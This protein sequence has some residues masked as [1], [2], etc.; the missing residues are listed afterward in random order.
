MYLQWYW[1]KPFSLLPCLNVTYY[2]Y[3]YS[4]TEGNVT[5]NYNEMLPDFCVSWHLHT[6]LQ[7]RSNTEANIGARARVRWIAFCILWINNLI[8]K[9]ASL[10]SYNPQYHKQKVSFQNWLPLPLQVSGDQLL[11]TSHAEINVLIVQ[12]LIRKLFT[13]FQPF[14]VRQIF[15]NFKT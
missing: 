1:I 7:S 11:G 3:V 14:M 10:P 9:I 12:D 2:S 5:I 6:K 13:F 15:K 8:K 4:I